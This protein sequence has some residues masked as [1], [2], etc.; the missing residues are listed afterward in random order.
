MVGG[1]D[2]CFCLYIYLSYRSVSNFPF[3]SSPFSLLLSY[4]QPLPSFPLASSLL[5]PLCLSTLSYIILSHLASVFPWAQS[6]FLSLLLAASNELFL[7]QRFVTFSLLPILLSLCTPFL[8]F[9]SISLQSLLG[10]S[11][12]FTT[13]HEE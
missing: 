4:F 11:C 13:L 9:P 2:S 5:S 7:C 6:R 12:V 3:P 10:H 1:K 8:T